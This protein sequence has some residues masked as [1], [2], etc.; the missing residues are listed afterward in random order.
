MEEFE[1]VEQ[2]PQTKR[3]QLLAQIQQLGILIDNQ[4]DLVRLQQNKIKE[5]ENKIKEQENKIQEQEKIIK[6][7]QL[8]LQEKETMINDDNILERGLDPVWVIPETEEY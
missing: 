2:A 5:Q 1:A 7:Q 8:K 3:E 6:E 4:M